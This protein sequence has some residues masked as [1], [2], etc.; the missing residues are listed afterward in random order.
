MQ[1]AQPQAGS[2][3]AGD[4]TINRCIDRV[5]LALELRRVRDTLE[6]L[7]DCRHPQQHLVA[8][9]QSRLREL[10]ELLGILETAS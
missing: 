9:Y 6:A 8:Q 7:Q 10:R 5:N 2:T 4:T 1:T 3:Q